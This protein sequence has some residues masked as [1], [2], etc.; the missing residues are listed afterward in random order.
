MPLLEKQVVFTHFFSSEN[1]ACGTFRQ[2]S[3]PLIDMFVFCHRR[4]K[5]V[6]VAFNYFCDY[7]LSLDLYFF[8]GTR[9]REIARILENSREFSRILERSRE[10]TTMIEI[11]R[12]FISV[13]TC[14]LE[15]PQ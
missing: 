6:Y 9:F 11:N 4:F 2:V 1:S 3:N 10:S 13:L 5:H 14:F 15:N 7:F 8:S 12:N